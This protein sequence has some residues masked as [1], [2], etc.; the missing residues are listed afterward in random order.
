VLPLLLLLFSSNAALETRPPVAPSPALA[1][2]VTACGAVTR[3][4]VMDAL[5][6]SVG[7]AAEQIAGAESTCDYATRHGLVTVVIERVAAMPDA[8]KEI[9][10]L[11]AVV[12]EG[13]VRDA[14]G[15]GARAFFLDIPGAGT[16][17]HILREHECL[18]ISVLGFG[19]PPDVAAAAEKIARKA[20]SR[21]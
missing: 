21:L 6:R 13:S 11:K 15:I 14:A 7:E 10:S 9:E 3:A 17:L 16:Q 12:P 18:L 1:A 20:L 19:E 4:E 5:G 8:R 2:P